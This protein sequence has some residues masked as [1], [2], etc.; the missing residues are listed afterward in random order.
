MYFKSRFFGTENLSSCIGGT[1]GFSSGAKQRVVV[2]AHWRICAASLKT[3][4]W[5]VAADA[6]SLT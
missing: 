6:E 1:D 2:V 4:S 3:E 5:C